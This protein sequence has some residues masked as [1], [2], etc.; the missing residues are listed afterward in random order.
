MIDHPFYNG[1]GMGSDS[2]TKIF[3]DATLLGASRQP[4]L[5]CGHPT[6]DCAGDSG[7]PTSIAGL[8]LAESLK[9]EQTLYLEEDIYEERQITPFNKI[10]VLV[11]RK[12]K[13][14]PIA[15]AQRLGIWSPPE[16]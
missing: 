11:H 3:N 1:A 15:E 4:C 8:S 10:R 14:I 13:Q 2:G 7:P 6:G 5:V 9:A 16:I 12:G